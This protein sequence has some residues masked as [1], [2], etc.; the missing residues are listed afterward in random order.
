MAKKKTA[1]AKVQKKVARSQIGCKC[2]GQANSQ[3]EES[4]YRIATTFLFCTVGS[5]ASVKESPPLLL[6]KRI[7][8]AKRTRK[9]PPSVICSYCPFCGV[10]QDD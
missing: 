9:G 8:G 3:L 7:D 6:I 10:K 2:I 5:R 4:G 1:S